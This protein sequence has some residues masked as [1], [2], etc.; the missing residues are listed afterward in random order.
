MD[1]SAFINGPKV[2][3]FAGHLA[4][5]CG[6]KHVIPCGNGTDALQFALMALGLKAGD[7]IIVPAFTYAA[8]AEVIGLLGY[9][10]VMVDVD[11]ASFNMTA[12]HLASAL[13]PKTR[14]I[15]PVHLFG[16]SCDM[17]PILEF[18]AAHGLY[19]I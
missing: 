4:D 7:E 13:T 19:V 15:V 3:E 9:T 1:T 8:T 14:A 10:P 16:Q 18:S 6:V 12:E 5:Y 11:Y 2:R 17:E